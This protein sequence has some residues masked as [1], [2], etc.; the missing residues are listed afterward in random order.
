MMVIKPKPLSDKKGL[1][2]GIANEHS[3]AYGCAE[4]F[5]AMGADLAISYLN[6]KALR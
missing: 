1:I 2:L 4:A 5:R 6:D 3:I